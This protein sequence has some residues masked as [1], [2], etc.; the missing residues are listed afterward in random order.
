MITPPLTT[1]CRAIHPAWVVAACQVF[2]G[3]FSR[4]QKGKK[5][6]RRLLLSLLSASVL[7]SLVGC[8]CMHG[9][10][11]CD[12][13]PDPC[14]SRAPW[15]VPGVHMPQVVTFTH[16]GQTVKEPTTLPTEK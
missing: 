13:D 12:P 5:A 8:C 7:G 1:L 9:V 10:C 3:V 4:P 15:V 16:L 14:I 6:M 11:D 2:P